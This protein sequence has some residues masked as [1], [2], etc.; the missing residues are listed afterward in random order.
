MIMQ[1]VHPSY[2]RWLPGQG[3]GRLKED[4]N[5]FELLPNVVK[6]RGILM[7]TSPRQT[8]IRAL[9]MKPYAGI[10]DDKLLKS[11]GYW[12]KYLHSNLEANEALNLVFK[13]FIT[14]SLLTW[15]IFLATQ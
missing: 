13:K 4:R 9:Q 10:I 8:D 2:P 14:D 6:E 1:S 5:I 7:P 12:Y 3:L 11:L 15:L